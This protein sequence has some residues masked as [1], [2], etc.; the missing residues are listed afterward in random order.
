VSVAAPVIT[1]ALRR[2]LTQ[3]LG[4]S[5]DLFAKDAKYVRRIALANRYFNS[6]SCRDGN[7][8]FLPSEEA[9]KSWR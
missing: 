3:A 8:I 2:H 9:N 7:K 6:R 5:I 4:A 1:V